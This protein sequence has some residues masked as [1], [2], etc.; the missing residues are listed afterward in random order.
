MRFGSYLK[1]HAAAITLRCAA[2]MLGAFMLVGYGTDAGAACFSAALVLVACLAA[3]V[4]DYRRRIGFLREVSR[5]ADGLDRP[6][7]TPELL[8]RPDFLEGRVLYDVLGRESKAMADEVAD[9]RTASREYRE[10]IETWVHEVKTPIAAAHLVA[11]NHPSPNVDAM[12]AQVARIEGY[13]EQA[14]YY[15][16]GS[17]LDRDFSIREV[18]LGDV[19]RDALRRNA[20]ALIDARVTPGLG[21]GLDATVRADP[22]WLSFIVGQLLVNAA[23]YRRPEDAAAAGHVRISALRRSRGMDAYETVLTIAD[24][25]IGIPESDVSRVFDKGFTGENGRRFAKSTG[26]GLYLCRALCQ[27]MGLGISLESRA[28]GSNTGTEVRLAFPEATT[29]RP[30]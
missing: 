6:Y 14:L 21:E 18:V 12:D 7:L 19:V 25:G 11:Q 23:K 2:V 22:K 10:Y 15:A 8:E 1:D 24:D 28:I 26:M 3:D 16:R 13:V 5:S 27:K 4:L 9:L 30:E 20:R 29:Q 17:S